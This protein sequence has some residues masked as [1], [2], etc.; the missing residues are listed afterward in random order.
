MKIS[1]I[2]NRV[3]ELNWTLLTISRYLSNNE[4]AIISPSAFKGLQSLQTLLVCQQC[5][6]LL[7]RI[8]S[9][10]TYLNLN[11]IFILQPGNLM[12]II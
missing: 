2:V 11:G 4:I 8:L 3:S 10:S 12:E 6:F 7:L 5:I 9:E 1:Y